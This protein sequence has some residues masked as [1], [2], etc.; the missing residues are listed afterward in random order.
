MKND[1]VNFTFNTVIING[2][3]DC[4]IKNKLLKPI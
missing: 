4:V 1:W 3:D 2:G